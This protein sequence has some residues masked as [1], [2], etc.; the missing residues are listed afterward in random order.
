LDKQLNAGVETLENETELI[1]LVIKLSQ[2]Q[3]K[4][5]IEILNNVVEEIE[6]KE[7][8]EFES[9]VDSNSKL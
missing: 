7:T 9:N 1:N 8:V 3:Q 6:F 4:P 2:I 5:P